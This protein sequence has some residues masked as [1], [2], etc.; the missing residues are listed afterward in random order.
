[1]SEKRFPSGAGSQFDSAMPGMGSGP[2]TLSKENVGTRYVTTAFRTLVDPENPNDVKKVHEL[3]DAITADQPGG[4]GKFERPEW[5]AVSQ[6]RFA[7]R[8]SS[9]EQTLPDSKGM[10]GTKDQVDPVRHLVGTAM[11]WGGNP[12]KDAVYLTITPH[13]NDETNPRKLT[14]KNVPVNGFW[15]ISMYNANG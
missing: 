15:S 14:V 3:Q 10:F 11:A 7:T 2:V 8:Y 5:D 6:K 12:E 13:N 9:S 1:M 4:S